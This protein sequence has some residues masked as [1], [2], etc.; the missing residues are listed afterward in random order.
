MAS[1]KNTLG[2]TVAF[3]YDSLR[4]NETSAQNKF[5]ER[6]NLM[7]AMD[8]FRRAR[9]LYSASSRARPYTN[10]LSI[11]DRVGLDNAL[12]EEIK[13]VL[14]EELLEERRKAASIEW[15]WGNA[16]TTESRQ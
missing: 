11:S 16:S 1:T 15:L 9:K 4:L 8:A 2:T 13:K 12:R 5:D 14:F 10:L 3:G 6:R 7:K